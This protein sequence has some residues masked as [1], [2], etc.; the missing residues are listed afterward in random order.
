MAECA[1]ERIVA[2]CGLV[3]SDCGAYKKGR[4]GGCHSEK[5]M[6]A[7]CKVKP[8]AKDRGYC[9]CAECSEFDDLKD[10]KKLNN[11]I[12]KIFGFVFRLDRIGNLNKI[13]E[14]GPGEFTP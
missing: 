8:C 7:V 13:K 5:P 1:S 2:Y 3:C 9:T 4:C 10:C 11:F 14:A 12:S 6:N